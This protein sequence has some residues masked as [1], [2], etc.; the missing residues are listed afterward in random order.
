MWGPKVD[1]SKIGDLLG[2]HEEGVLLAL[3]ASGITIMAYGKI[4]K[5]K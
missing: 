2:D 5:G 1:F 3:P 4:T